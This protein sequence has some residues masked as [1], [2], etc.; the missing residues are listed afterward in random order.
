MGSNVNSQV[1]L[2]WVEVSICWGIGRLYRGIWTDQNCTSLNFLGMKYT[3][4]ISRHSQLIV[5]IIHTDTTYIWYFQ[6]GYMQFCVLLRSLALSETV[7]LYTLLLL[8]L[9]IYY[10]VC[11]SNSDQFHLIEDTRKQVLNVITLEYTYLISTEKL[12]CGKLI[13]ISEIGKQ[14]KIETVYLTLLEQ[15]WCV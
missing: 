3:T 6:H 11:F 14:Q 15:M 10:C 4:A 13:L 1:T 9:W 7:Y 8:S 5:C 12:C 2:S